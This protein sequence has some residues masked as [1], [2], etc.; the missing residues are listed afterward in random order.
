MKDYTVIGNISMTVFKDGRCGARVEGN[1]N[2]PLLIKVFAANIF[3]VA[4]EVVKD[5]GV[6]EGNMLKQYSGQIN[7][8][9]DNLSKKLKKDKPLILTPD[10]IG[11]PFG[12]G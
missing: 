5:G 12:E 8:I 6:E 7:Q 4:M 3:K 9:A 1:I 11:G 2:G 10:I